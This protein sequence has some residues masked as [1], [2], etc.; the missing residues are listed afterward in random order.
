VVVLVKLLVAVFCLEGAAAPLDVTFFLGH[1]LA[2][3][4]L[5]ERPPVASSCLC[6]GMVLRWWGDFKLSDAN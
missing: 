5:L 1:S 2:A 4:P 6:F 3:S